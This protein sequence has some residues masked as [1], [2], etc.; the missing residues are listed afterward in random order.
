M[1][2]LAHEASGYGRDYGGEGRWFH[3]R[4]RDEASV[5]ILGGMLVTGNRF[6]NV[7]LVDGDI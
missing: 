4:L 1:F 5:V 3:G 2:S 6:E 7:S